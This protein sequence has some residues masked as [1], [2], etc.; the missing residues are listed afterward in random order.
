MT[1]KSSARR[2]F[3][4]VWQEIDYVYDQVVRWF[5]GSH[6]RKRAAP[7]AKRLAMLLKQES[8]AGPTPFTEGAWSLLHELDGDLAAAIVHRA[9]EV[10]LLKRL[11]AVAIT[12]S[13]FDLV[14]AYYDYQDLVHR[15]ERLAAL[16]HDTGRNEDAIKTCEEARQ[17]AA[18]H[19]LKFGG[20]TL[21][22]K[23]KQ[24]SRALAKSA[25]GD[26]PSRPARRR[27]ATSS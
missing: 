11:F 14:L 18:T 24:K 2:K 1:A 17:L 9:S 6:D 25:G 19:G 21:L 23:C 20:E 3:S 22:R 26:Q 8:S 13:S 27:K 4:S 12:R 7:F 16:Y 15:L 5:C 10:R